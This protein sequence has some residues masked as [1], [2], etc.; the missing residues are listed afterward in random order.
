MY[1]TVGFQFSTPSDVHFSSSISNLN[2]P[3]RSKASFLLHST[4]KPNPLCLTRPST[5]RLPLPPPTTP[6]SVPRLSP[7]PPFPPKT[8]RLS[9]S[10]TDV[11]P[12]PYLQ[13]ELPLRSF[14][15]DRGATSRLSR[16]RMLQQFGA[17]VRLCY[18]IW[19]CL[20]SLSQ[21]LYVRLH[22]FLASYH[23][24]VVHHPHQPTRTRG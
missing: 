12:T 24:S 2:G 17:S 18:P 23:V 11:P 8:L 9:Q 7:F 16:P 10:Y 13:E 20:L 1:R 6:R 22:S 3:F 4:S 19:T 5:R 14:N 21:I 15:P